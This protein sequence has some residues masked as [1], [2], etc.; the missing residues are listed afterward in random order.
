MSTAINT[1]STSMQWAQAVPKVELHIHLEG[2]I[3]LDTLWELIQQYGGD[4]QVPDLQALT[5]RFQYRDF[6]HFIDTWVWKN[7]FIRTTADF[8]RIATAVA[9]DLAAQHIR[10]AEAHYSPTDFARHGLG[11][12]EITRA[13]REGLDQVPEIRIQLIA[14]V[15][16]DSSVEQAMHT[17]ETV[18]ELR[19]Y[20]V[21]G[22][23]LGGSEQS[24]PPEKMAD[25]F[26]RARQLGMHVTVH[27]GEA[28][29]AASIWGAIRSLQCERIGHAARAIEDPALCDYLI[30]QRIP[31][32]MCPLSNLRTGVVT[33]IKDHPVAD[34]FRRGMLVTVNTDDPKMFNNTLAEE[35]SVL[36]ELF[37]L[38]ARDICT[39]IDNGITAAWLSD[40]EKSA[41]RAQF[42]AHP[43]WQI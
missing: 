21:I 2:A 40:A 12:A 29:G 42:M 37:G 41:L 30:A 6:P 20:G 16:R 38:Q 22:I 10:Y 34:F 13:I 19:E 25:V 35:Y 4:P 17:L 3:P 24:H 31:L 28:A 14:D 11:I 27:A 26:A 7:R 23:G 5:T 32:E 43:A 15:V 36:M 1:S 33:D 9:R 39:I 18:A 8:T